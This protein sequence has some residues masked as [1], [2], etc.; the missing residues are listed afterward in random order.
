VSRGLLAALLTLLL[1]PASAQAGITG[2]QTP[3]GGIFCAYVNF[4]DYRNLRCDVS[5]MTNAPAPKPKSCDYDYGSYFGLTPTGRGRRLCVSDTPMD[6]GFRTLAYGAT[7][8][9]GAFTCRSRRANLRCTN[10]RG[11]GFQISRS[12]QTLF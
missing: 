12:K 10:P 3:S 7:W 9:R 11:H 8:K 5:D 4:D 6:P 2:F 1:V